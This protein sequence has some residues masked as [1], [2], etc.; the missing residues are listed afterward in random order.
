MSPRR[1]EPKPGRIPTEER[2]LNLSVFLLSASKPQTLRA[3]IAQVEG[4]DRAKDF[5]SNRRMFIRDRKS[6]ADLDIP[7]RLTKG[8]DPATGYETEAYTIDPRDF[9][10]PEIRFTDEE[11]AALA[12]LGRRLSGAKSTPPLRELDWAL[13]KI[14]SAGIRP[15]AG[16]P[17][18]DNLLLQFDRPD[19]PTD[20]S[21]I[22]AAQEAVAEKRRLRLKYLS[23]TAGRVIERRVDPYGIFLRRGFWYLY[24][25]CHLRKET[26]LFRMDRIE[27]IEM[28][29]SGAGPEFDPPPGFSIEKQA[30]RRAPWEFGDERPATAEIRFHPDAFW[31]VQN[32]WGDLESVSFDEKSLTMT[33]RAVNET[34]LLSWTLEFADR[35]EIL[36]PPALRGKIAAILKDIIADAN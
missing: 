20:P 2:L 35:A 16:T 15:A 17:A 29:E 11:A 7:I 1:T 33:V 8:I 26:R 22:A 30:R 3:I 18:S 19:A 21:L 9:Y 31:Q 6:L 24:G 28:P 25:Y 34:A 32:A 10:L 13:A 14:T 36:S 5:E 27:L 4:Y 12:A 23:P